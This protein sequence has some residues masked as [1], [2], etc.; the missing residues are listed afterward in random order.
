M[1][2][3]ADVNL[4]FQPVNN[5][6]H[7]WLNIFLFCYLTKDPIISCQGTGGW[8]SISINQNA[9]NNLECFFIIKYFSNT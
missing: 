9:S 5:R 7:I 4:A 8:S 1:C 6:G 2:V 3:C